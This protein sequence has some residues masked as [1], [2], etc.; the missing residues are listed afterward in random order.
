LRKSF[1]DVLG[2]FLLEDSEV[3]PA[4]RL[5]EALLCINPITMLLDAPDGTRR[6]SNIGLYASDED[7]PAP[8]I[9]HA[10]QW[11]YLTG[12]VQA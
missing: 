10:V 7:L 3:V 9:R 5:F 1:H 6:S 4:I 2:L 12:A 11:Y 8:Q